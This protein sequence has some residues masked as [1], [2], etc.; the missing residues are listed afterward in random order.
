EALNAGAVADPR[1]D[2]LSFGLV[3]YLMLTKKNLKLDNILFRTNPKIGGIDVQLCNFSLG[4]QFGD[5]VI[6]KEN[7][8]S[9]G[10]IYYAPEA[11]N[12]GA[13]ADPRMD[14]LSFGLVLYLMLTKN[15]P[16]PG[17][18]LAE[19]QQYYGDNQYF[20]FQIS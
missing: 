3:L 20:D 15:H 19:Y 5:R 13:V 10:G 16:L 11:L 9:C 2:M 8:S 18:T 1:M 6:L 17:I 7:G 12:A 14:M 4:R